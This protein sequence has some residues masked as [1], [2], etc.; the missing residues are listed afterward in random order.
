MNR[1]VIGIARLGLFFGFIN[2]VIGQQHVANVH[3]LSIWSEKQKEGALVDW[4]VSEVK[5]TAAVYR[6]KES[7]ELILSN[8]LLSRTFRI[9]PNST[10]IGLKLLGNQQELIRA[11]KP[12]AVVNIDGFTINVGGLKGQPNLAFL[13][14]DWIDGLEADPLSFKF[15]GFKIGKPEKHMEW[16]RVRHHAPDVEWPPKGVKLQMDYKMDN[17][18][19]EDILAMSQESR[20]GRK[21]MYFDDFSTLSPE[22]RVRTSPINER[23]SFINEGKPGEIY[24]PN[25]SA[26]Y[27]EYKL[28]PGVGLVETS[29]DLGT[30]LS[31]MWGPG[32]ALLWKDRTIKFNMR[33]GNESGVQ[34]NEAWRFTVYDGE[35]ENTRAGGKENVD[36]SKTWFLRMR[37][38]G[39]K[40]YCEA[41]PKGGVWKTYEAIDFGK[42]VED[43]M[44]VRIGKLGRHAEGVDHEVPGQLVRLKINEFGVYGKTNSS[45]LEKIKAKFKELQKVVISVNY[46]L[47]DKVPVM[48]KWVTIHNGSGT[49]IKVDNIVSEFLGIADHDPYSGYRGREDLKVKPNIH[50]ETD[51]AFSSG[52]VTVANG[53]TVHWE[54]DQDY[55]TQ[56][57]WVQDIPN[58]MKIY[59]DQGYH[60]LVDAE[61]SFESIRTFILPYD[62]YDKER[63]GLALRKMYRTIAPWVTEN[64]MMFHLTKSGW[65]EFKMGIDQCAEVG[66]EM[67]NFSFGSGFNPENESEENYRQMKKY[68]EYADSK[69]IKI[70]TYSLLASRSISEKDDVINPKTGKRGG[71]AIF[72]NSPCLGSEWGQDYFRRMYRM[73]SE[74]GFMTFTHDGSYPG[75]VCASEDHPGH[76]SL[77][78]SQFKQWK[79][80][81]DFYKWC[82][83]QGVYL[84]VPD[85]YYLSG[86]NQSGVGYRENNWSLP[87][88]HQLIHTRQNIFDGTWESIPTM[89]WSFIPLAQYHGGGAAAT[90]EPLNEH[91]DHYEMMLVSNIG[92]GIQS[93]LRG[94]RLYDTQETKNMVKG[95]VDWY[96][97]YR[98][99][100]ESDILHLRRSDGRDLDYMMHV[101]PQLKEKGFLLVFNPT[102]NIIKKKITVPLYYTGITHVANIR[103]QEGKSSPMKLNRNYEIELE[104]EVAPNWY[105]WYVVE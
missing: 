101:N 61:E 2:I 20:L 13:Y 86:S 89:R 42:E 84:R 38:E 57:S 79:M 49:P 94:P 67:L 82:K 11:V 73:F 31:G 21:V 32:I 6:N 23:S 52:K 90:I 100:L 22:L 47:Y 8:G 46:E 104:V 14:P 51:Y 29:I 102:N 103:E 71:F 68:V 37:I 44:A 50:F 5:D 25:N 1:N 91:L 64:P 45:E 95:V 99:I 62:S 36:F 16:K 33:P 78:D 76:T 88:R 24:T 77:G 63:N 15:S 48:S 72:G 17:L 87:R 27:A 105:N 96:K 70:G 30:D 69:G 3:N 7:N 55:V 26:V 54:A 59:P 12:E 93:A 83:A 97:G 81:S 80:I 19:V 28:A 60:Y 56:I 39:N 65:D 85:Y 34:N 40:V 41:R 4:L 75:D 10:T 53:Q 92:M 66:Y 35:R 18:L 74:T 98:D 58:T 43:P 9:T